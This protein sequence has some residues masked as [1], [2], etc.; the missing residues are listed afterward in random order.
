MS[1][2]LRRYENAVDFLAALRPDAWPDGWI[3]RGHGDASWPLLPTALRAETWRGDGDW[4]FLAPYRPKDHSE[5][6]RWGIELMILTRFGELVDEAG[7]PLPEGGH[8]FL[9]RIERRRPTNPRWIEQSAAL[10]ALAQHHGVPTRLLDFTRR[11]PV[12]AY[13]A[14]Q[15]PRTSA[16]DLCVYALDTEA[17]R[18]RTDQDVVWRRLL[19]APRSSNPNLHAQ[20]GL[21]VAW[22]SEDVRPIDELLEPL[23][24]PPF[25]YKLCLPRGRALELRALLRANGVT[26]MSLFPGADGIVQFMKADARDV[27][28]VLSEDLTLSWRKRTRGMI[29]ASR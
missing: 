23:S 24:G 25:L 17:I 2:E 20:A 27:P 29:R 1:F 7:L 13:F 19:R 28:W 8:G 4:A 18:S 12:A 21:F 5:L 11:G 6:H 15:P 9:R 10:A 16:E 3:F 14:V 22:S 26:A